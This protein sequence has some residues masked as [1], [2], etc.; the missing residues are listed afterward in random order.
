MVV[1]D[2]DATIRADQPQQDQAPPRDA[3]EQDAQMPAEIMERELGGRHVANMQAPLDPS[4][5][6]AQIQQAQLYG[7]EL[8]EVEQDAQGAP[9]DQPRPPTRFLRGLIL[10]IRKRV[11]AKR[12][13]GW[14]L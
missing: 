14:P 8:Y 10:N 4:D 1:E 2:P 13:R 7:G 9:N 3:R 5:R 11:G 6:Q 12:R